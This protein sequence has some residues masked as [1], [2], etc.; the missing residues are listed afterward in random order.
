[1][2]QYCVLIDC[3]YRREH[4]GPQLL[5]GWGF[6]GDKSALL[7]VRWK[8]V[9]NQIISYEKRVLYGNCICYGFSRVIYA[10]VYVIWLVNVC[11]LTVL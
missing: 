11:L 4:A 5:C 2:F 3:M 7:N 10:Y 9:F 8:Y 1:M 6:V